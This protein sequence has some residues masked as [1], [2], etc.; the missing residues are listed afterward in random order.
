MLDAL[1]ERLGHTGLDLNDLAV[2]SAALD[3]LIGNETGSL[4]LGIFKELQLV[5]KAAT[6]QDAVL[7]C[8]GSFLSNQAWNEVDAVRSDEDSQ[9]VL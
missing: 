3:D 6:E 9:G 1:E 8:L 4:V 7:V 5:G 2:L